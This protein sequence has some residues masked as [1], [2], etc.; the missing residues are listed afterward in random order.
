V[1]IAG[2]INFPPLME[3]VFDLPFALALF[4]QAIAWIYIYLVLR[5]FDTKKLILPFIIATLAFT[6][7]F[8][9]SPA[10]HVSKFSAE[11]LYNIIDTVIEAFLFVFLLLAIYHAENYHIKF[12]ALG[13]LIVI[14]SDFMIRCLEVYNLL[15]PGTSL[16]TTWV[17]GLLLFAVGLARLRKQQNI[18]L[19]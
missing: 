13:Y 2:I 11:G 17:L 16:E 15:I 19:T 8:Y 10:W 5:Q 12:I 1:N 3:T 14:V 7:L 6:I 18:Q 9:F 4:T